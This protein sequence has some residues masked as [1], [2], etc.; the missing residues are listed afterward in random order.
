MMQFLGRISCRIHRFLVDKQTV[1]IEENLLAVY[2]DCHFRASSKFS[3]IAGAYTDGSL[4]LRASQVR[5]VAASAH[6][7]PDISDFLEV[8][9][10]PEGV[11][12]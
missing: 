10:V 11:I 7:V 8:L 1:N 12:R 4:P 2:L 6:L 5:F 9:N 3:R